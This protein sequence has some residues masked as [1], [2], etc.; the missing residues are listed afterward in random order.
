MSNV[1]DVNTADTK[2]N[3]WGVGR[4]QSINGLICELSN[5]VCANMMALCQSDCLAEPRERQPR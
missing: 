4:S 5:A 1:S 2:V 3:C